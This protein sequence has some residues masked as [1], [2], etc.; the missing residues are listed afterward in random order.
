[1]LS[2]FAARKRRHAS[3]ATPKPRL[4]CPRCDATIDGRR[5]SHDREARVVEA[6]GRIPNPLL[7]AMTFARLE[8]LAE[9]MTGWMRRRKPLEMEKT[10]CHR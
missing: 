1:M 9:E 4:N 8:L 2:G 3:L 7:R 5:S 6:V 10:T